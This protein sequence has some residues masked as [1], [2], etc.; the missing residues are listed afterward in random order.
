MDRLTMFEY[1]SKPCWLHRIDARAKLAGMVLLSLALIATGALPLIAT[2]LVL[3][4]AFLHGPLPAKHLW[5]GLRWL[6]PLLLVVVAA[7]ALTETA[8]PHTE[9]GGVTISDSG[10]AEGF[11]IAWRLV[12]VAVL[13]V[14]LTATT[15]PSA[16]KAAVAWYLKPIPLVPAE[17]VGTMLS[18]L[19]RFIPLIFV[20]A[21]QTLDAQRARAVDS[22]KNPLYRLRCF[23]LPFFRRTLLTADRVAE[24]MEARCY[25]DRRTAPQMVFTRIDGLFVCAMVGLAGLMRC[26]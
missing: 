10:L 1:A 13:G 5:V 3:A 2:S 7:R 9:L 14:L 18:L 19:L 20:Q 12:L 22:R 4:A 21:G 26:L 11:L 24:A 15:A 25:S 6:A 17:R 8:G 23:G 16:I